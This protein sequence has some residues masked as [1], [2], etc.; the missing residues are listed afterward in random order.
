MARTAPRK[1]ESATS[2]RRRGGRRRSR[3][4]ATRFRMS[5]QAQVRARSARRNG[6][7]RS[8]PPRSMSFPH[9]ALRRRGLMTSP[10]A[11][12]SPRARSISISATRR[13][14]SRSSC[15]RCSVRWSAGRRCSDDRPAGPHGGRGDR[16]HVRARSIRTRRQDV[17]RLIITRASV[18]RSLP[19]STITRS[20]RASCRRSVPS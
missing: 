11:P 12:T 5:V 15:A 17:I 19:R 10:N 2:G 20:S 9:A 3:K 1:I 6:A 14:C 16:R 7:R 18:F 4:L 13:A 8:S